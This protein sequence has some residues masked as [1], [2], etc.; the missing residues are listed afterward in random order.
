MKVYGRLTRKGD[1][2]A[3]GS[4]GQLWPN[5][6]S[7][8]IP[9]CDQNDPAC[10]SVIT[11]DASCWLKHSSVIVQIR[12]KLLIGSACAESWPIELRAE[13]H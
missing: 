5:L 1:V 10:R 9:D 12:S 4:R 3:V 7:S 13:L 6:A 11:S 2:V 8:L